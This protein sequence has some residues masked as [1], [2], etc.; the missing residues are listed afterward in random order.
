MNNNDQK[1]LA[2]KEA[3][4]EKKKNIGKGRR[5]TPLT[6]CI[7]ELDGVK[8]NIQVLKRNELILLFVK[9][10]GYAKSA[11][12]HGYIEGFEINGFHIDSWI[13]DICSRLELIKYKEEE[14]KLKIMEAALDKLLSNE[15]KTELE[16]SA[17]EEM[18]KG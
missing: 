11:V 12:E 15:K 5:F 1:I 10:D 18:L 6:S 7:I 2:L 8:S 16:I 13:S 14:S 4:A 17:I 9:L 3:I